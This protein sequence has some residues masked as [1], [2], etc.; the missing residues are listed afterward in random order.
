[1]SDTAYSE[2][3]LAEV[4][5]EIKA[6]KKIEKQVERQEEICRI[7][8]DRIRNWLVQKSVSS[9]PYLSSRNGSGIF[10]LVYS[11]GSSDNLKYVLS[12]IY[13]EKHPPLH[14]LVHKN[15]EA[16]QKLR[17]LEEALKKFKSSKGF[18]AGDVRLYGGL[19]AER[20]HL[21]AVIQKAKLAVNESNKLLEANYLSP[22]INGGG[23]PPKMSIENWEDAEVFAVKYMRWLGF[24]DATKTR[25]GSDEG[26]DVDASK[27]VA[28]VKDMGTG[29]SRPMLQQLFGVAAAE[30]KI[31]VFFARSYAKTAKEWGEKY[32]V[33]L[34]QF[35]LKG[36]VKPMSKKAQEL[37]AKRK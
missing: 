35:N 14:N 5:E 33:A 36:E 4:L 27:A 25:G 15:S 1:M 26:K 2:K 11:A 34:F 21:E 17:L 20:S 6:A 18:Y 13:V 19:E 3:R 29:V 8:E 22:A 12:G 37:L 16:Q 30:K 31:P 9:K 24:S 23:K 7:C 10:K 32:K 28:Q